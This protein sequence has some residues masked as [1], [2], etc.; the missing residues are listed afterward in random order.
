MTTTAKA[1]KVLRCSCCQRVVAEVNEDDTITIT[2]RH[3]RDFHRTRIR[4]D[5]IQHEHEFVVIAEPQGGV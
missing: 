2:V 4:V 1:V 3:D 5:V